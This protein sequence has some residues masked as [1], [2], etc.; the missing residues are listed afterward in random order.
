M[1]FDLILIDIYFLKKIKGF[2]SVNIQDLFFD[3]TD[4][5]ST[6]QFIFYPLGLHL[7]NQ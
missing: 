1:M 7:D 4:L 2:P 5:S 6:D 3:W